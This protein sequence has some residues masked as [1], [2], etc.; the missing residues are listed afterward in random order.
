MSSS[1]PNSRG[2]TLVEAMIAILLVSVGLVALLSMQ[3]SAWRTATQTDYVGRAAMLLS[4]ELTTRELAIM[5]PCNTVATGTIDRNL[6]S[7]GRETLQTGDI[8]FRVVTT[9]TSIAT[10]VWRV[11]VTVTWPPINSTGIRESTVVT[12]QEHFRFGC[13]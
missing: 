9:T 5:N 8:R 6:Y 7:S 10:G 4:T 1:P 2:V 11:T 13:T 12:R 3:P